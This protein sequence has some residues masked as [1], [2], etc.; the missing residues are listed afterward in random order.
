MLVR[1]VAVVVFFFLNLVLK[2]QNIFKIKREKTL[3]SL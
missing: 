1:D 3:V 2:F